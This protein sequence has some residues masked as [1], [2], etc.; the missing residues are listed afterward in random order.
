MSMEE[1]RITKTTIDAEMLRLAD[2][3]SVRT[4]TV[5]AGLSHHQAK[6]ANAALKGAV[7]AFGGNI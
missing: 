3:L 2:L 1:W 6:A 4:T 5:H 7:L